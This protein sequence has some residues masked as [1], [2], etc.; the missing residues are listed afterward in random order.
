MGG[1]AVATLPEHA[2]PSIAQIYTRVS[3]HRIAETYNKAF[4]NAW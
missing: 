3:V 1:R 2:E 4:P